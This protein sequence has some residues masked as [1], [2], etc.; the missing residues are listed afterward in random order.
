M[1]KLGKLDFKKWFHSLALP[2][3][4]QNIEFESQI[5]PIVCHLNPTSGVFKGKGDVRSGIY[6]KLLD[7]V[8]APFVKRK[9]ELLMQSSIAYRFQRDFLE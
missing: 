5:Y 3:G 6:I 8:Q 9:V 7:G 1:K 4:T 2:H